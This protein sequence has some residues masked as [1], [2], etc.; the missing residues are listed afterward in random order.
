MEFWAAKL[1]LQLLIMSPFM[2][3]ALI[4]ICVGEIGEAQK[5]KKNRK[6]Q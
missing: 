1:I 5:N 2:L 6:E 3:V 4:L